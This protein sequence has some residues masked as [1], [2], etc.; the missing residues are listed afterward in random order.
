L[1]PALSD[2]HNMRGL[3]LANSG[4]LMEARAAYERALAIDPGH[5]LALSNLAGLDIKRNPLSAAKRLTMAAGMDPQEAVIQ[6][7][8]GV[9]AHNFVLHL[10]WVIVAGGLIE[11]LVVG[12]GGSHAGRLVVV[13]ALGVLVLVAAGYF[14][15]QLPRGYRRSPITLARSM[16]EDVWVRLIILGIVVGIVCLIAFGGRAAAEANTG[17]LML[18]A[19]VGGVAALIRRRRDQP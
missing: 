8:L 3:C 12:S 13:A 18:F 19:V 11:G 4:R 16:S 15:A 10:Q 17:R 7:N 6:D 5:A 9:A 14:V 2:A 1:A